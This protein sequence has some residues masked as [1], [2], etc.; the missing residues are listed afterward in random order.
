M[1]EPAERN[2]HLEGNLLTRIQE[3]YGLLRK[4]ERVVAD[5]LRAHPEER[6]DASITELSRKLGVSEATI[7]RVTRALGYSGF[8]DMKL[9]LAEDRQGKDAL[10]NIPVELSE[11]DTLITTG[12][13]LADTLALSVQET[14][15][16][17][18]ATRIEKVIDAIARAQKLVFVGVGGAAAICDEAVHLFLKAGIDAASYGDGYTQTIAAATMSPERIMIG[19]SHTGRT[20]TVSNALQLAR[21]RGSFTVAITSDPDSEVAKAADVTLV[22]WHRDA[23]PVALHGD[24]LEGRICQLYLLDLLYLGLIFRSRE[25][26][27]A[28]LRSTTRAL[29]RYYQRPSV[30]S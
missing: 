14:H 26:A 12:R 8:Q 27:R 7:S 23:Q 5:Y 13:K 10:A 16:L 19:I 25:G 1:D 3:R 2:A 22:T 6:L 18:D 28:Q 4:S 11:D 24:F 9:S 21:Q 30:D 15:K 17:L 29:E 20:R